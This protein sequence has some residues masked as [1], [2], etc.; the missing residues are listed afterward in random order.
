MGGVFPSIAGTA[1]IVTAVVA[2]VGLSTCRLRL[3]LRLGSL[4]SPRVF[5]QRSQP[6][7]TVCLCVHVQRD[8]GVE[9]AGQPADGV[10]PAAFFVHLL[11]GKCPPPPPSPPP[12]TTLTTALPV[13]ST[14]R[15]T[16]A[17]PPRYSYPN[18]KRSPPPHATC[19][20]LAPCRCF[21][22]PAILALP[23]PPTPAGAAV[24]VI[25]S[26]DR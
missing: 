3:L 18:S 11:R 1:A 16:L 25:D 19:C 13:Y 12:P 17:P 8:G 15:P 4:L 24:L 21:L 5:V 10:S 22:L 6:I 14:C 7:C 23:P 2:G 20:P 9:P 26:L